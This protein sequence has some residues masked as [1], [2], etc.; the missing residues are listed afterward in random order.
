MDRPFR[1]R[2][3]GLVGWLGLLGSI[4]LLVLYLPGSPS[5][6]SWPVEWG[7]VLFWFLLGGLFYRFH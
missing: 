4:S 6:L 2:H 3:G 1:L 7:L 5:A